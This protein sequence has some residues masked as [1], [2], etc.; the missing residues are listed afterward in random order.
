MPWKRIFLTLFLLLVFFFV[1]YGV[2]GYLQR[3]TGTNQAST[4]VGITVPS[5][6]PGMANFGGGGGG[7]APAPSASN[8]GLLI[9]S[10]NEAQK[11]SGDSGFLSGTEEDFEITN[12]TTTIRTRKLD[13]TCTTIDVLKKEKEIVF[14]QS[15][16]YDHRCSF[17]FKVEKPRTE[18]VLTLL[19]KLNPE[20]F[21]E[22][23][24][25]I[26]STV[27]N[28]LTNEEI[29][30]KKLELT[31]S[32]LVDAQNSYSEIQKIAVSQSNIESLTTLI[33]NK[34]SIINQLTTERMNIKIE[35][36]KIA[37]EKAK[38][39]D[40]LRYTFFT[41]SVD[42]IV[43]VDVK[44]IKNSWNH[45]ITNLVNT[46]NEVTRGITLELAGFGLIVLKW[47]VY[48]VLFVALLKYTLIILKKIWE[49]EVSGVKEP[50]IPFK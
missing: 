23:T 17:V 9:F 35:M 46:A 12:Y 7:G 49:S 47:F 18:Y 15:Q 31:E 10:N 32:T 45:S 29:L 48:L 24:Q 44:S 1:F 30:K 42:D 6:T 19:K 39:L 8:V 25:S 37:K 3:S 2:V 14:E 50:L 21:Q 27:E 36:D 16:Q 28:F 26:K 5:F 40:S 33:Q 38:Q 20:T 11:Q 13:E 34:L 4:S 43:I 22:N 41:V